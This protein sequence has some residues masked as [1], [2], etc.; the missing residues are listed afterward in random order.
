MAKQTST[1]GNRVKK[2]DESQVP[3]KLGMLTQY[4]EKHV[5]TIR[6]FRWQIRRQVNYNKNYSFLW[7]D[8]Q[9][10]PNEFLMNIRKKF[11]NWCPK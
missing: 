2:L 9:L 8:I 3:D 6:H 5:Q 11:Q 4:A 10:A 1:A 7:F